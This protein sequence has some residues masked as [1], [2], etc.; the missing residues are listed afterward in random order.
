MNKNY[1]L[2]TMKFVEEVNINPKNW[3][4][5]FL[6]DWIS[7]IL[8]MPQYVPQMEMKNITGSKMLEIINNKSELKK[9]GICKLGHIKLMRVLLDK[10]VSKFEQKIVFSN[11]S[12]GFFESPLIISPFDLELQEEVP[13]KKVVDWDKKD[14]SSWLNQNGLS[15]LNYHFQSNS[16]RGDI[17]TDLNLVHLMEMG[18]HSQRDIQK[19]LIA[20]NNLFKNNKSKEHEENHPLIC[21]ELSNI[22]EWLN[23]LGLL[24]YSST[25]Y[26]NNITG[27]QLFEIDL[28]LLVKLGINSIEHQNIILDSIF[29]FSR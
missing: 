13:L 5:Q 17:L 22:N 4:N 3:D 24:Q 2:K 11:S 25:F 10:M 14:I 18:I 12:A 27:K 21:W 1:H 9:L 16:I 23:I 15:H 7:A 26:E 8:E 6:C 28:A 29:K 20:I 19:I